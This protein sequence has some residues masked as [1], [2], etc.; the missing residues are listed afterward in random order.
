MLSKT[1]GPQN[2]IL[3]I[4]LEEKKLSNTRLYAGTWVLSNKRG[5]VGRNTMQR[6]QDGST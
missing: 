1:M 5:Q 3:R 4:N 6:E 2:Y